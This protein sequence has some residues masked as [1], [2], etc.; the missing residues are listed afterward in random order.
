MSN[1]GNDSFRWEDVDERLLSPET[2][3][4]AEEMSERTR[5]AESEIAFETIQTGNS[6]GYLPRLFDFHEQ[7]TNEWVERL[8]AVHRKVWCQQNKSLSAAFIRA[9]RDRPIAQT[10]A[11]RKSSLLAS[12]CRQAARRGEEP[13][14]MSLAEW[15]RRMDRLATRWIRRLEAEAVAFEYRASTDHTTNSLPTRLSHTYESPFIWVRKNRSV[16]V[17]L[18]NLAEEFTQKVDERETRIRFQNRGNLNTTALPF[19]LLKMWQESIDERAH[20]AEEIYRRTW[21]QQGHQ[22][23]STFIRA[24]CAQILTL[25]RVRASSV[26]RELQRLARSTNFQNHTAFLKDFQFEITRLEGRWQ[27]RLESEAIDLEAAERKGNVDGSW[28]QALRNPSIDST[29]EP[30]QRNSAQKM[31]EAVIG[32]VRNPQTHTILSI[33]EAALYFE[34]QPR[35]VHRW[36]SEGKL[37]SGA[38]RGSITI[39]SI[40][41]W[42]KKRSRK[43]RA[44]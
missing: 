35:T 40:L 11:A 24:V 37:R 32:K 30:R 21:Q 2:N 44:S 43:R 1:A 23:T 4:L 41:K 31:H 38:R 16:I 34:V 25:I 9:I 39:D 7:L 20:R 33:P 6:A 12:V 36:I 19:Q 5:K 26:E 42:Q 3:D 18:V 10:I 27:R 15:S 17:K 29:L 8:Y 28:P 22:E 14:S 13:N